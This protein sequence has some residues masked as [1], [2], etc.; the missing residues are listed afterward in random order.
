MVT[1]QP[2]KQEDIPQ[3]LEHAVEN[4]AKDKIASGN[5]SAEEGLELSRQE[6]NKLLP[7][8]VNS[9]GNYIY[10][11]FHDQQRVGMIWLAHP[12]KEDEDYI[13]DFSI[14]DDYQ[15]YGYGKEA[16]RELEKIAK[17]LGMTKIELHV[18]GQNQVARN[19]YEKMGYEITNVIMAKSI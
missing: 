10:S 5:W 9:K 16:M 13:Y 11:I 14:L 7:D 3:Y 19:L 12:Y 17:E 8:G 15:G 2:M 18:F 6:F 4:Y 1:L